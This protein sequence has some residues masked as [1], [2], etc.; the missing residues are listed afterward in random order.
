MAE[1]TVLE[2]ISRRRMIS[3]LPDDT[4]YQAAC[5]MTKAHCGGIL[6]V[7]RDGKM[8]GIFTERDLLFR[9]VAHALDPDKTLLSEVMTPDPHTVSPET[10]ARE[11]VFL[12]R[13]HRI[14][15]LPVISATGDIMGVFSLNDALPREIVDA[16]DLS[17]DLD[18]QLTNVLA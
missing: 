6:I 13:Q 4:V 11:A 14:R 12:M 3:A 15:H 9:V 10:T 5:V 1:R 17:D 7:D 16:A 2:P 8:R 18:R